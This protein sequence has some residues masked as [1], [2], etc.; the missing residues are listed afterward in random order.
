[1][2]LLLLLIGC[3]PLP[4][5]VS[6]EEVI[7][8]EI[9]PSDDLC[10]LNADGESA[11]SVLACVA[12]TTSE[13]ADPLDLTLTLSS[14][15]WL[16]GGGGSELV[17]SVVEDPCVQA[18]FS[19]G[20]D[21]P[22]VVVEAELAGLR[23]EERVWLNPAAIG[24]VNLSPS[25]A[26][27]SGVDFQQIA[28]TVEVYGPDGGDVS[29][30]TLYEVEVVELSGE[31]SSTSIWPARGFVVNGGAQVDLTL[32]GAPSSVRLRATATPPAW[33]GAPEPPGSLSAE[34][35]LLGG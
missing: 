12:D 9:C 22:F 33:E 6:P 7:S 25:T 18:L 31:A 10:E 5:S 28:L 8:L 27:L 32:S 1:M 15:A 14:G 20:T 19:P 17:V 16:D 26:Q 2:A 24:A 23:L 34:L 35:V 21:E 11:V 29:E 13:R 3:A 4:A 30:G